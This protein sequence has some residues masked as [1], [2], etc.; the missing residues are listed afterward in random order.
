MKIRVHVDDRAYDVEVTTPGPVTAPEQ[1]VMLQTGRGGSNRTSAPTPRPTRAPVRGWH[2]LSGTQGELRAPLP[3]VV[4]EILARVGDELRVGDPVV[5]LEISP[6][7]A[8]GAAGM[9]GSIRSLVDGVVRSLHVQVGS[10][11]G[12]GTPLA[13]IASPSSQP[14]A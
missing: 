8:S 9:C 5:I 6:R 13:S 11:V 12:P 3:G 10:E 14:D 2:D 7:V 1:P 4:R